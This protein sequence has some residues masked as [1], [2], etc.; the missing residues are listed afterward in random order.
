MTAKHSNKKSKARPKVTSATTGLA[1]I[2]ALEPENSLYESSFYSGHSPEDCS[3]IVDVPFDMDSTFLDKLAGCYDGPRD[4]ESVKKKERD[5]ATSSVPVSGI[6]AK[7]VVSRQRIDALIHKAVQKLD[8]LVE[9]GYTE[10]FVK[11]AEMLVE[12]FVNELDEAESVESFLKTY[13]RKHLKEKDLDQPISDLEIE[14]LRE[15][16]D[17]CIV[18]FK[19][20]LEIC[21]YFMFAATHEEEKDFAILRLV[22]GNQLSNRLKKLEVET[23]FSKPVGRPKTTACKIK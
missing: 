19:Q 18:S 11:L 15:V 5:I 23:G 12:E 10:P 2:E 4:L 16:K 8:F 14:M 6:S 9:A 3:N 1:T 7:F 20:S 17:L 13:C 22:V 21:E